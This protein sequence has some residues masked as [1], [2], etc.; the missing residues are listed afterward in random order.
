MRAAF[1]EYAGKLPVESGALRE[2]VADVES[3]MAQGGAVLGFVNGSAVA[4]ARYVVE[5]DGLYVG[6]VSVLPGSGGGASPLS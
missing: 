3:V 2:T 1:A 5:G 6:R 4:S